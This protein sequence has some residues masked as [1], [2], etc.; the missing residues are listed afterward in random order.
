MWGSLGWG[1]F[2]IISGWLI[3]KFSEGSTSKNYSVG[4]Y[5]MA[6]VLIFDIIV[7]SKLKH[8]QTKVSH[9]IIKDVGKIFRSLRVIVFFLW[10]ICVGIATAMIW[11][12]LFWH[13]EDLA[14][15][16]KECNYDLSM[17]TLQGLVM[18]IQCFGGEVPFFFFSGKLLK[19][20]GHIAC[21]NLV[22]FGFVLRF[23]LYSII[24]NPW[25][26][27]PIE[28]LNGITF[29]IFYSTMASY[30][31]IISPQ[32]TEATLQAS[33]SFFYLIEIK[34]IDFIQL[35]SCWCCF[36][37]R[38]RFDWLSRGWNFDAKSWRVA[39]ILL[40]RDCFRRFLRIPHNHSVDIVENIWTTW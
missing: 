32:G 8:T 22:L 10:C 29:G 5:L 21:M 37:R 18:G 23:Y 20:F 6:I 17:K 24:Q 27:L 28:F 9:S 30:A 15:S 11:N 33:F 1:T 35:G 13:L 7:S 36:R 14:A 26:V 4:F 25:H 40:L 39:N 34:L 12:F 2:S 19:K 3:D 38:G 16:S 31:S